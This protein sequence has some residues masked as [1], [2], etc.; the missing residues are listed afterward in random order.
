MSIALSEKQERTRTAHLRYRS[1]A[2][3]R[4]KERAYR[5]RPAVKE[6][7]RLRSYEWERN[8]KARRIFTATKRRAGR[9]G[10]PFSIQESD[11]IIPKRC[12]V[13]GVEL[14]IGALGVRGFNPYSP[15]LD[16]IDPQLGYIP[17]NVC[18]IS[19]KANSLKNSLTFEQLKAIL[20]YVE[21]RGAACR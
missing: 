1:K 10:I 18:I 12:P 11:I 2:G 21:E 15:S 6:R 8:N 20:K 19:M 17:G 5:M 16:R 9:L 14:K 13:F 4:E 7:I 3:N